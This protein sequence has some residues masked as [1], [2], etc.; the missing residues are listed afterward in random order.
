MPMTR[1]EVIEFGK[2]KYGERWIARLAEAIGYDV[3][4]VLR[5]AT[6]ETPEVSRRMELEIE[7]LM[8][9]HRFEALAKPDVRYVV[10]PKNWTTP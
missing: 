5:V 7:K 2:G 10:D 8:R 3:S 9:Q 1:E 4:S 6:G